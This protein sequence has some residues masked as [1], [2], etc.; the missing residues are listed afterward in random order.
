MNLRKARRLKKK[1]RNLFVVPCDV[2]LSR[3]TLSL[4]ES[5]ES[6]TG[7]IY[8]VLPLSLIINIIII[9]F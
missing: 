5:V 7:C 9:K 8:C 3:P 4:S 6:W 2:N 1:K